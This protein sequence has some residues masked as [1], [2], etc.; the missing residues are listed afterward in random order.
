M[1]AQLVEQQGAVA[2]I[3]VKVPATDVDSAFATVLSR[4]A[5]EVRVPGFRPGRAP[6]GVVER[7]IGAEALAEEVKEQLVDEAYPKAVE[8]L[9][10]TPYSAHFH[11]D[12]PARG[13]DFEFVVHAELFPEVELPD[14]TAIK[15]E[16]VTPD[17]TEEDVTGTIDGVR[18]ENATLVPV[19]RPIEATDW[20]LLESLPK[21]ENGEVQ[22]GAEAGS[23]STFPVDLEF[24]GDE[25][26]QQ[27]TG[28]NMGDRVDVK[29]TDTAVNDEAGEPVVRTVPVKV[30]DVKFKELPEDG[31]DFATQ[32]GFDTW[33]EFVTK[34]RES[35]AERTVAEA[36][37]ARQ[38]ELVD[39]LI[40]ASALELPPTLVNRRK[41]SLLNDL[42]YDLSQQGVT[43]EEYLQRLEGEG[44]TE[45]FDK[46]LEE[47]AVKGVT[48]DLLLEKLVDVRGT[49]LESSEFMAAA[50]EL[51][52]Q[53]GQDVG[54]MF[55]ELGE[56][57]SENYRYLL[58]RDKTVREL[59]AEL[60]GEDQG[61]FDVD[62]IEE[63]A[64]AAFEAGDDEDEE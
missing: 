27:L 6:T 11:A 21:D 24:A 37:R 8:E 62:A 32:L 56:E 41:R 19:D 23:G 43:F 16:T 15:L 1:E 13:A 45:Q 52:R 18:R 30:V 22:E 48:R 7:K 54:K 20:V 39:K 61:G 57:W 2:T 29:L 36:R 9:S 28:K 51:A 44:G 64:D 46:E 3:N 34:V 49:K 4:L 31:D 59:V 50:K 47:A 10:L 17:V 26:K 63:A 38:T 33:D 42:A 53:R 40:A 35:L 12:A 58:L 14:V 5:R 60:T 25:L 55:A